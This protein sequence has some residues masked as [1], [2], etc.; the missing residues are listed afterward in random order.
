MSYP[1]QFLLS[2]ITTLGFS[3]FF[4]V[5]HRALV[6]ASLAG[7]LGWVLC[8]YCVE[9]GMSLIFSNFFAALL[10]AFLAEILARFEKS[11]VTIYIVPGILPLVP[12]FRIYYMMNYFVD[13][14]LSAGIEQGVSAFFIALALALGIITISAC[15]KIFFPAPPLAVFKK[16][17][18]S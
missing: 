3:F 10:I 5:R 7:A 16:K 15:A 2:F 12:G 14:N 11:P 9:H 13:G 18:R 17:E 4:Q 6:S 1:L 8:A